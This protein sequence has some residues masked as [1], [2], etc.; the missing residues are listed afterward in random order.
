MPQYLKKKLY[1]GN[2]YHAIGDKPATGERMHPYAYIVV[3]PASFSPNFDTTGQPL[4]QNPDTL[5]S[6]FPA[7]VESAMSH[8]EARHLIPTLLSMANRDMGRLEIPSDLSSHS[9]RLAKKALSKGLASPSG[10]GN[11]AAEPVNNLTF[12]D[13]NN[14]LIMPD[15][16]DKSNKPVPQ[17]D[18]VLA[19][20]NL[21]RMLRGNKKPHMS[22]QF[23]PYHGMDKLPGI[24]W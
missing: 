16:F 12:E 15:A 3:N 18:V 22:E 8:H 20:E 5:F 10:Y 6:H 2:V 17:R 13:T 19:R 11:P 9:S 23:D 24:D 7:R 14:M 21:R 4:V 1:S